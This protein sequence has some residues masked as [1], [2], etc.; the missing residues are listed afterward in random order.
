MSWWVR[1]RQVLERLDRELRAIAAACWD[2]RVPW[3]AR[4]LGVAVVAYALSP[5]DLVPDTHPVIGVLD[6]LILVPLGIVA[7]RRLIPLEVMIECRQRADAPRSRRS[8]LIAAAVIT[9]YCIAVA[10][11]AIAG[12]RGG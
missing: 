3:Y 7:V 5:I 10:G 12:A 11:F 6:D 2:P 8:R 1:F 9:V 4:A